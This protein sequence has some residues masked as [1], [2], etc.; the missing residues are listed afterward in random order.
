[1]FVLLRYRL[2]LII[3]K[4]EI[5]SI[6]VYYKSVKIILLEITYLSLT[7]DSIKNIIYNQTILSWVIRFYDAV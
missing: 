7:G 2:R 5:N 4:F 1:M 6:N 3:E